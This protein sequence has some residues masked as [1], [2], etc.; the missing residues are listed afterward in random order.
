MDV[1]SN[2]SVA[3]TLKATWLSVALVASVLMG[4]GTVTIGAVVSW[5]VSVM[6]PSAVLSDSSVAQH[7][8]TSCSPTDSWRPD[9]ASHDTCI[10]PSTASTAVALKVTGVVAPVAS[11]TQSEGGGSVSTGSIWSCE[12]KLA[13][14][15][16]SAL[17]ATDRMAAVSS[18]CVIM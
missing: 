14:K 13:V 12:L 17:L 2:R 4:S 16:A 3:V 5:T 10:A 1:T 6:V 11:K 15:A 18:A 7:L 8:T 9:S